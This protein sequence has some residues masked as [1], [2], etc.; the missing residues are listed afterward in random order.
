MNLASP[1]QVLDQ[2]IHAWDVNSVQIDHSMCVHTCAHAQA[3]ILVHSLMSQCNC[4]GWWQGLMQSVA[5]HFKLPMCSTGFTAAHILRNGTHACMQASGMLSATR[6]AMARGRTCM[7]PSWR[8]HDQ[9]G[10]GISW[11]ACHPM[12]DPEPA[13]SGI[14][15]KIFY[16]KL[17]CFAACLWRRSC[18]MYL[19][20][21]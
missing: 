14:P 18:A 20:R 15:G 4:G 3:L 10:F 9:R 1:Q 5:G 11:P 2:V 12:V 13:K 8:L 6:C 19:L 21:K 17:C 16:P 7:L